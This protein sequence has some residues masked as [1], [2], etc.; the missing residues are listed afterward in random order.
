MAKI[1][2]FLILLT[3]FLFH[4]TT[5]AQSLYEP[6]QYVK[7]RVAGGPV[8]S[9]FK[10]DPRVTKNVTALRGFTVSYSTE[11]QIATKTSLLAGF[12]YINQ[13]MQFKGYYEAPGYTYLF[14]KTF[15]YAHRIRYQS[16]QLPIALKI[17]LNAEKDYPYTPYFLA[18]FGFNYVFQTTVS[19][20]SDSTGKNIYNGKTIL[21]YENHLFSE[22]LNTFFQGGFGVQKNFRR[23]KRAVFIELCYRDEITRLHYN[24]YQ[25]SS[26]V[27]FRN[28]NLAVNMG[29]KF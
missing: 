12:T 27:N 19:I 18:G 14:D 11:I 22:K 6:N 5:L 16:V 23:K 10:T 7:H 8:I 1:Q 13:G 26:N 17:N 25:N 24:G 20:A 15:A 4:Q 9:F 28:S 3:V 2:Q 21:T 29:M